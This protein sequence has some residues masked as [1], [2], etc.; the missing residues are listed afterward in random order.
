MT[1]SKLTRDY[2]IS[3][4]AIRGIQAGREYYSTMCPLH[5]LPKMFNY[6]NEDV[7]SELRAQRSLNKGRI[8]ALTRYIVENSNSHVFSAIS[9]SID[10][11]V[12]FK[13]LGEDTIGRKIGILSVP[14]EAKFLINDGQH[15]RAAIE[16]ALEENPALGHETI[17]VVLFVD[18]GLK[19]SQ[20]MFA[21]LN[22][23]AVRP[24]KSLGILYDHRDPMAR[25]V[26]RLIKKVTVFKGMTET[27][28]STISNRSRKLFTLSSIYL[29]TKR[30]LQK[31]VEEEV[32]PPEE[33]LAF[34]YWTEIAKNM[35]DW[36]AA[37]KREVTTSELRKDYVH[38]HGIALQ[39]LAIAGSSLIATEPK[40]WKHRLKKI[41][42][43]NWA[44]DNAD[45][46]EGRALVGGRLNKS[47]TNVILT[48][49][50]I[51]KVL[52]LPLDP[53]EQ[54]IEDKYE[55]GQNSK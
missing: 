41:R 46:W 23:Y 30:L 18:S 33:K 48:A 25:L 37:V 35:P 10:A 28:R 5:L 8:P 12:D 44:R 17:T 36:L 3:F 21:D 24:T 38:A 13:A 32:S 27:A 1:I 14:M 49:N 16:A 39:A 50:A 15:R 22:R 54:L 53:S 9:A 26:S 4:P 51:K 47:Q 31:K 43:I 11:E 34:D 42:T 40:K 45:L 7:P 2:T 29:A 19:Q 6:N 55:K 20:Q 52:N